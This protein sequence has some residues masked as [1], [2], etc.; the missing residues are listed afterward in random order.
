MEDLLSER[1]NR[2]MTDIV[3]RIPRTEDEEERRRLTE[4]AVGRTEILIYLI[5]VERGYLA[6]EDAA[7]FWM[8]QK[9]NARTIVDCYKVSSLYYHDY[10][11]QVLRKRCITWTLRERRRHDELLRL[12]YEAGRRDIENCLS[13]KEKDGNYSAPYHSDSWLEERT[14]EMQLKALG[15]DQVDVES[16]YAVPDVP[17]QDMDLKDLLPS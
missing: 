13:V 7:A 16:L 11:A 17:L 12:S 10:L 2:R 3:L 8:E 15:M 6:R 1:E 14:W 5:P 4:E 9:K